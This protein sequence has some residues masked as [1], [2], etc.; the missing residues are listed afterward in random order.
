M[1]QVEAVVSAA[2]SQPLGLGELEAAYRSL[3][4][5]YREEY[6][7]YDLAAAALAQVR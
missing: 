7:M 5:S 4:R 6:I 3:S 2:Q 1:T